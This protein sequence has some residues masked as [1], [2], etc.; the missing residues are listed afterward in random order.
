MACSAVGGT[1]SRASPTGTRTGWRWPCWGSWGAGWSTRW[2][3]WCGRPC[4]PAAA[5]ESIH[6][7]VAQHHLLYRVDLIAQGLQPLGDG[8]VIP[9]GCLGTGKALLHE[10]GEHMV[11]RGVDVRR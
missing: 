2:R 3:T 11:E 1:I 8:V 7:P 10:L 4:G 5:G 6:Q 9:A